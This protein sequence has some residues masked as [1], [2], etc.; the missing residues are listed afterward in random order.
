VPVGGAF[1]RKLGG[2]GCRQVLEPVRGLLS[3]AGTDVDRDV[4]V[5]T[6]LLHEVH[7]FM[8][9]EGVG[10]DDASPVGIQGRRPLVARPDAVAPVIFVG[11]AAAR[12]AHVGNLDGLQRGD[13]VVADAAGVG[14]LRFRA[15]PDA[16]I[17]AATEVLGKLAEDIAVDLRTRPGGIDGQADGIA[18]GC[19]CRTGNGGGAQRCAEQSEHRFPLFVIIAVKRREQGNVNAA[20]H[21]PG[22]RAEGTARATLSR[23]IPAR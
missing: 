7:E 8:R 15:H 3:R 14:D 17:N 2:L 10:L 5:R 22:F 9:A 19:G 13:H 12:P 20:R 4:G 23:R 11:E 1:L 16:F 6:D 18:V 21:F